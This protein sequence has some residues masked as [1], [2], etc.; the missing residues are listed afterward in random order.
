MLPTFSCCL[1]KPP[2]APPPG[3]N[4]APTARTA[5]GDVPPRRVLQAALANVV[6][7]GGGGIDALVPAGKRV[8]VGR[9]DPRRSHD[10]HRQT[11]GQ[12]DLLADRLGVRVRVR[13]APKLSALH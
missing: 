9:L 7:R 8:L 11:R 5:V 1:A 2:T 13:K 4:I 12:R 10:R 3:A 6:E